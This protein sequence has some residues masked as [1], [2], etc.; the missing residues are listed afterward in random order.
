M[1]TYPG[2]A[3]TFAVITAGVNRLDEPGFALS[4]RLNSLGSAVT[5][6]QKKVGVTGVT[7]IVATDDSGDYQC[8][9]T[10]DEVQIN[11]AIQFVGTSGGGVVLVRAGTYSLTDSIMVGTV[12]NLT[13]RGDGM[14]ATV[15]YTTAEADVDP[16]IYVRGTSNNIVFSDF[17][18]DGNKE[19]VTADNGGQQ[20]IYTGSGTAHYFNRIEI[21]NVDGGT[22]GTDAIGLNLQ[23]GNDYVYGCYLHDNEGDGL[24]GYNP[25][26]IVSVQ[27]SYAENNDR[28]GFFGDENTE[29]TGCF[30]ASNGSSGFICGER[31]KITG[32]HSD[33]N[34]GHGIETSLYCTIV[35]NQVERNAGY[36]LFVDSNYN[37][38]TGN[39]FY[40]SSAG[41]HAVYFN[42]AFMNTFTSNWVGE[43]YGTAQGT[44]C[45][46]IVLDGTSTYNS[47]SNNMVY[48]SGG[49]RSF[50]YGYREVGTV[51]DYNIVTS[52]VF[53]G[54]VGAAVGTQGANTSAANNQTA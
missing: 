44:T 3:D 7:T 33:Q 45:S 1:S 43:N 19:N 14:G 2:T 53:Y 36:Q 15:F 9:G 11:Q 42:D 17:T 30:S 20:G 21:K 46:A 47:I 25:S 18:I 35:G 38:I 27:S 34:S 51:D 8:D 37:L 40:P 24:Y 23:S 48:T 50:L 31:T 12:N 32:C 52:N 13:L 41:T 28:F 26:K 54:A 6:A 16:T 22:S 39:T 5:A 49:T 10:A 4:A 29:L